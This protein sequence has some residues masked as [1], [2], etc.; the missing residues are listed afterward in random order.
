MT[1]ILLRSFDNFCWQEEIE[2]WTHLYKFD[3]GLEVVLLNFPCL[4][5]LF[6]SLRSIFNSSLCL[7]V[8]F[9]FIL[10]WPLVAFSQV[11]C[12]NWLKWHTSEHFEFDFLPFSLSL[13]SFSNLLISLLEGPV[14]QLRLAWK[15]HSPWPKFPPPNTDNHNFDNSFICQADDGYKG[16]QIG[17]LQRFCWAIKSNSP[18]ISCCDVT[19][20]HDFT[21]QNVICFLVYVD[22]CDRLGMITAAQVANGD[23]LQQSYSGVQQ[24]AA[25]IG[26]S[27]KPSSTASA[28]DSFAKG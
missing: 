6:C 4:G 9:A 22:E 19:I 20:A 17:R 1:N 15:Q 23:P 2:T 13:W 7:L 8:W 27:R 26:T 21:A 18:C 28:T 11:N 3:C 14:F 10:G 25:G 12:R 5:Y 24:Y 16:D